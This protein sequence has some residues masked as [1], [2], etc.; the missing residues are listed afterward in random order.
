MH[1][2]CESPSAYFLLKR[3]ANLGKTLKEFNENKEQKRAEEHAR[4]VK[5]AQQLLDVNTGPKRKRS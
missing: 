5:Q 2:L 3:S 4:I 1:S